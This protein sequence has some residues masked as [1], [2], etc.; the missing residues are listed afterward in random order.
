LTTS[1]IGK[2]LEI[3][4]DEKWHRVEEIQQKMK[5][6]ENQLQ[7]IIRFLK[8]YSF[9]VTDEKDKEIKLEETVRIFLKQ[10]ATS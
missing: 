10:E 8:E 3:L 1:K 5:L 9:I 4:S 7:Q 6:N 2:I